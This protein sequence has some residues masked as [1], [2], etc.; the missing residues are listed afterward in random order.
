MLALYIPCKDKEEARRI[1]MELLKK[2]LIACSNIIPAT[3]IYLWEGKIEES[4]EQI[5]IAKT[6]KEKYD[7]IEK[8][9]A[10]LHSYDC[11]CI[12]ALKIEKINKK[13]LDWLKKTI[14]D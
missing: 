2:K 12:T 10:L 7:A 9:V 8:E 13:Y 5:I 14:G 3:S 1:S 6:L 4:D 11:P